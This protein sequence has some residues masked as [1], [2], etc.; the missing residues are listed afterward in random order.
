MFMAK[1]PRALRLCTQETI[2]SIFYRFII[3]SY[4]R[5][6]ADTSRAEIC[7]NK[8]LFCS[9]EY[10]SFFFHRSGP[11]DIK[12]DA[13]SISIIISRAVSSRNSITRRKFWQDGIQRATWPTCEERISGMCE[14]SPCAGE[15]YPKWLLWFPWM[16]RRLPYLL[17]WTVKFLSDNSK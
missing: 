8:W 2:D 7:R 17:S 6:T 5:Y 14:W 3:D 10:R 4:F 1:M 13:I 11:A 15:I 9:M 16:S 12:I